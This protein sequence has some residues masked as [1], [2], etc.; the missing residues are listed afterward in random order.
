MF[1]FSVSSKKTLC[2]GRHSWD[3]KFK[4]GTK[5][6]FVVCEIC[7]HAEKVRCQSDYQKQVLLERFFS[8]E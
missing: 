3:F 4:Q 7:G 6:P 8:N 5:E 1:L 2:V